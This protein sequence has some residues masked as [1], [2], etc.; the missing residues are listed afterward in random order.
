MARRRGPRA[1]PAAWA[2]APSDAILLMRRVCRALAPVHEHGVVHRDIKPSNV[3]LVGGEPARACVI[4]FGIARS[5]DATR[6]LTGAGAL[7]GTLGYMAPSRR[8]LRPVST[9]ARTSSPSAACSSS[10]SPGD[11]RSTVTTPRP[12]SRRSSP[13]LRRG[14]ATCS[15]E[16]RPCSTSS[17]RR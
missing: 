6:A 12:S 2:L 5:A 13:A 7:L 3:F 11:R 9:R 16:R 17:S 8:A 4:D 15:R 14:C 10:A 1:A